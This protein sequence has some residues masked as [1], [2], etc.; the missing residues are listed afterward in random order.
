MGDV[1]YGSKDLYPGPLL[2]IRLGGVQCWSCLPWLPRQA[3]GGGALPSV[4]YSVSFPSLGVWLLHLLF[5]A[6]STDSF[7]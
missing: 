5:Q 6:Y 1:P 2:V 7:P 3:P 4:H